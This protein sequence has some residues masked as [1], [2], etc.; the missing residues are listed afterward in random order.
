MDRLHLRVA[1]RPPEAGA[2]E[3]ARQGGVG[4]GS[5][6]GPPG[7]RD[8]HVP[9]VGAVRGAAGIHVAAVVAAVTVGRR[10]QRAVGDGP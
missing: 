10:G 5:L 1:A 4:L 6:V 8:E 7:W 3:A 9:L 2:G